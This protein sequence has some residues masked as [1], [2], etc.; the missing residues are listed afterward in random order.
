M[1]RGPYEGI[2]SVQ[3]DCDAYATIVMVELAR[4]AV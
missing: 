3:G 2:E 4:V 1:S